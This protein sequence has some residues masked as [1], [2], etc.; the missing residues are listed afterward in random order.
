MSSWHSSIISSNGRL[1]SRPR[2][3]GTTQKVQKLLQPFEIG[4]Q[5]LNL[6]VL[7][8]AKSNPTSSIG[9]NSSTPGSFS[10]IFFNYNP[11]LSRKA[12][13]TIQRVNIFFRQEFDRPL[14]DNF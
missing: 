14:G 10:L 1:I 3:K 8:G 6:S 2:V 13:P 12:T 9:I 11:V 7:R 5:A 4:T